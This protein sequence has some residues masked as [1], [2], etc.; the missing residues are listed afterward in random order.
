M[1]AGVATSPVA[2]SISNSI[3]CAPSASP[4]TSAGT[5]ESYFNTLV[6][7]ATA[8]SSGDGAI[9]KPSSVPMALIRVRLAG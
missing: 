5:T 2:A 6:A 8:A 4:A 7:R 3:T 9:V 1:R